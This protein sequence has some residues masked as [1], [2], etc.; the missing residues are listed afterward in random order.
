M[1]SSPYPYYD[2]VLSLFFLWGGTKYEIRAP[3]KT[4][5]FEAMIC[6]KKNSI[7]RGLGNNPNHTYHF[8]SHIPLKS[9][10]VGPEV[11]FLCTYQ[12]KPRRGGGGGGAGKGW[13]FDKF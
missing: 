6:Q 11:S 4:S 10:M 12:C 3:L 1:L 9:E 2:F 5:T 13:V 7:T 8:K